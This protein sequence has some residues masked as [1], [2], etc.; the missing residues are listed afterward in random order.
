MQIF[1]KFL[2]CHA[3]QVFLSIK[4]E[5]PRAENFSFKDEKPLD[6][7]YNCV[8]KVEMISSYLTMLKL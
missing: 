1:M 6:I 4:R 2:K 3:G 5:I 7:I 8:L